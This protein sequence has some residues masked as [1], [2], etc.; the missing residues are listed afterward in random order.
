MFG[1]WDRDLIHR[2]DP[3]EVDVIIGP[4]AAQGSSARVLITG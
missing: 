2:V 4:N 3:G 1:Y